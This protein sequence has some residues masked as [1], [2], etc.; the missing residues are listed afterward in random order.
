MGALMVFFLMLVTQHNF[1]SKLFIWLFFAQ[2]VL[3]NIVFFHE[4][5]P[6]LLGASKYCDVSQLSSFYLPLYL[7]FTLITTLAL[8]TA[9][10]FACFPV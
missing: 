5:K 10:Q 4:F 2:V 7:A 3:L 9:Y 6:I 8:C 1:K